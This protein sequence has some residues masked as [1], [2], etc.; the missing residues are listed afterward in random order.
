MRVCRIAGRRISRS[1]PGVP[2]VV[3]KV[4]AWLP[5]TRKDAALWRLR[6]EDGDEE[7]L[8]EF[9]LEEGSAAYARAYK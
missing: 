3:G 1:F 4:V 9:E 5:E 2:T 6:H 8:E 7:D